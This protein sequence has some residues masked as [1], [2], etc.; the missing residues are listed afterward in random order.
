[1]EMCLPKNQR[2]LDEFLIINTNAIHPVTEIPQ[3]SISFVD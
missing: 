1:M 3:I 2:N